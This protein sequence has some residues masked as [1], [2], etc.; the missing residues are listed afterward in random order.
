MSKTETIRKFDMARKPERERNY[1]RPITW[2]LSYPALWKHHYHIE[3]IG[4]EGLKPPFLVMCNH[5]A[6]MDFKVATARSSHIAA[7]M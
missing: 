4:V 3:R 1:L 7:T 2:L 5:S 6:F